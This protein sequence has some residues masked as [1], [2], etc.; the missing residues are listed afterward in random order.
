MAY[1]AKLVENETQEFSGIA[2]TDATRSGEGGVPYPKD[3]GGAFDRQGSRLKKEGDTVRWRS[4]PGEMW[5]RGDCWSG[6]RAT[7]EMG[8]LWQA[9]PQ[10]VASHNDAH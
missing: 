6:D 10:A 8:G 9:T 5:R 2:K 7:G 3:R 4:G 1:R